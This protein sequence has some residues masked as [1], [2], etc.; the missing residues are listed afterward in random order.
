MLRAV[1]FGIADH[2]QRP[3]REQAAQVSIASLTDVAKLLLTSARA[4]LGYEPDPSRE[5]SPR[6]ESPWITDAG[7]Q[8]RGQCGTDARD[9]IEPLAR[10]AGSVPGHDQAVE[11]QDLGLQRPELGAKSDETHPRDLRDAVVAGIGNDLEQCLDPIAANRGDDAKLGK[12]RADRIDH[13]GL[14]TH[15]QVPRAMKHQAALL[16]GR[17]GRH[18]PHI[19]PGNRFTDCLGISGIMI[20]ATWEG[21]DGPG[22]VT[23]RSARGQQITS[24]LP[25]KQDLSRPCQFR[26]DGPGADLPVLRSAAEPGER[27]IDSLGERRRSKW[28]GQS[29]GFA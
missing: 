15:E 16:L 26:R 18:E 4:L 13:R 3:G 7:N 19:G 12:M 17:L 23:S 27:R 8:S 24:A 10:L 20:A 9:L 2:G 28:K 29:S 6:P 14:L 5:V 25:S 21:L 22:R 1:Q 11:L